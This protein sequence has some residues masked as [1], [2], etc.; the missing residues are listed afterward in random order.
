M[1]R[2]REGRGGQG[3]AGE[4]RGEGCDRW[5]RGRTECRRTSKEVQRSE[6]VRGRKR[7][8]RMK[9]TLGVIVLPVELENLLQAILVDGMATCARETITTTRARQE[10]RGGDEEDNV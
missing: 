9:T 1:E 4:G 7:S 5:N 8:A 10:E 6:D 2:G 3:R